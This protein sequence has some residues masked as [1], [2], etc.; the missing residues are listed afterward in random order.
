M[1]YLIKS[2][3][4]IFVTKM[5]RQEILS[6]IQKIESEKVKYP[7]GNTA[8]DAQQRLLFIN[9]VLNFLDTAFANELYHVEKWKE[10][11]C[12]SKQTEN[13]IFGYSWTQTE[14]SYVLLQVKE[15]LMQGNTIPS[16]ELPTC[17]HEVSVPTPPENN[18]EQKHKSNTEKIVEHTASAILH[19]GTFISAQYTYNFY[20]EIVTKFESEQIVMH[21]QLTP[22]ETQLL[23]WART[24]RDHARHARFDDAF[25]AVTHGAQSIVYA[26][27][28]I[29]HY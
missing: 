22:Y 8:Y 19:T 16:H 20:N 26:I 12:Q 3:S 18:A 9:D 2:I 11:I 7:S 27:D 14:A 25:K 17:R 13:P 15:L 10:K 28:E 5:D 24:E 4:G 21:R 1:Y 6:E 23:N 29:R